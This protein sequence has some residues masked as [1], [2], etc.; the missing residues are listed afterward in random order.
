M[1]NKL[2]AD[3]DVPLDFEVSVEDPD[4]KAESYGR[5]YVT[6]RVVSKIPNNSSHTRSSVVR[7]YSDFIFL[8]SNLEKEFPECLIPP[9]P[10]KSMFANILG[11]MSS[12]FIQV[13]VFEQSNSDNVIVLFS[14]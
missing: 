13:L 12:A 1:Q 6:Y 7:R 11:T 14:V 4:K 3:F 2:G 5:A 10:E 8:Q 9:L